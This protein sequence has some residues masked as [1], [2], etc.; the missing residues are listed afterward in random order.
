MTKLTLSTCEMSK[1][2]EFFGRGQ[3]SEGEVRKG[4]ISF[5]NN[6]TVVIVYVC[7]LL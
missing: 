7:D 6:E 4:A 2:E 1:S 5:T 3:F